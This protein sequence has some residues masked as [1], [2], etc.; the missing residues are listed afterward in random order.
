ME[1]AL[2]SAGFCQVNFDKWDVP[3][4]LS[5]LFLYA[6]KDR[7]ELYLNAKVRNGI[8]A[9][10]RLGGQEIEKG[11]EK[12]RADLK[13]GAWKDIRA[14]ADNPLGPVNTIQ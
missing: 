9:F 6:C 13:S 2:S 7:P 8:S 14:K 1:D 12:L 10:S 11:L 3:M 4:G 5:D